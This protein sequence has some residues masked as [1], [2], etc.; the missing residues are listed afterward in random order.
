MLVIGGSRG[1]T[2]AA[3][4]TAMA[5]LRSGA[6][7]VHVALPQG[8]GGEKPYPEVI[9]VEVPGADGQFGMAGRSA[10]FDEAARLKAVAVGP[11]LGRADEAKLLVREL[12]TLDR[13]LVLDADGL[14]AFESSRATLAGRAAAPRV[15]TPHLGE[16]ERLTGVAAAEIEANRIDA[17]REWAE[18]WQS[19]VVLKGAPTVI[20]GPDRSAT[21]NPTGNPGMATAGTGD[22][23]TGVIAALIAQRIAPLSMPRAS[24]CSCTAWPATSPRRR[25][26]APKA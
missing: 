18:R 10:L 4:M 26:W 16:M 15:L 2:G 20:G 6:G 23:L 24:A 11:G 9:V 19:V 3:H 12:I 1:M 14:N 13:P 5:A 25:P 7:L 17:P 21:V 8:A 22:V